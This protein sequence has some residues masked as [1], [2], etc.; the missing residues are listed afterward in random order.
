MRERYPELFQFFGGYFHQ[1]WVLDAPRPS[2][3]DE[4]ATD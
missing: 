3:R 1:D 2:R 4:S